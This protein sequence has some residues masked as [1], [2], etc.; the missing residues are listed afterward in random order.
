MDLMLIILFIAILMITSGAIYNKLQ[1]KSVTEPFLA[2]L[3]GILV[4]PMFS[5][6]LNQLLPRKILKYL[7][8]LVNLRLPLHLWL[9]HY[10]SPAYIQ[11]KS[12]YINKPC[13]FWNDLHVPS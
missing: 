2:I 11:K 6:L 7:R 10:G 8:P 3:L 12:S 1:T 5:T 4:G 13:L 9:P